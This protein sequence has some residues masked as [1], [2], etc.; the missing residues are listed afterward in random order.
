MEFV[1]TRAP[2]DEALLPQLTHATKMRIESLSRLKY[3]AMWERADKT[4]ANDTPA[5]KAAR[6]KAAA[7]RH[8]KKQHREQRNQSRKDK[9]AFF[10]LC[11]ILFDQ[12]ALDQ[13]GASRQK[14]QYCSHIPSAP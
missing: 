7:I 14:D 5:K 8:R 3:P 13:A 9:T 10:V 4:A 12:N 2:L 11:V 1:F 6:E